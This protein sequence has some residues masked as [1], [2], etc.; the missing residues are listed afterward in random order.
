LSWAARVCPY[1]PQPPGRP[2]GAARA[3]A[4][5]PHGQVTIK[6][7]GP[8]QHIAYTLDGSAPSTT[9]TAYE[10]PFA[11]PDGGTVRAVA[12][13]TASGA[14]SG[15]VTADFDAASGSWAVTADGAAA[16]GLLD[17]SGADGKAGQPMEIV[18]DLGH[19]Y[20]LNGFTLTPANVQRIDVA[21][22]EKMGPP[23]FF[24]AWVSDDG[25]TW[26]DPVASGEFA[27]IAASRAVQKVRF[28]APHKARYLRINLPRAVLDKPIITVAGVG[29]L[30]R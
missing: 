18:L 23:G 6:A 29:I 7:A 24:T 5:P 12:I 14:M 21:T 15:V 1:T 8:G 4:P 20:V 25:K 2:R 3:S 13:K 9:A 19:P 30:T 11:L 27:N 22:A 16:P 17:G 26:G 10:A 28:A